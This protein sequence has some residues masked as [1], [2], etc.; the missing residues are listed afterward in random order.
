MR[1]EIEMMLSTAGCRWLTGL[2]P[3]SGS[4]RPRWL[5]LEASGSV[6]G[7][8]PDKSSPSFQDNQSRMQALVD[9]LKSKVERVVEGGGPKA[10]ERH[11]ARGK[12]VAR[13]R[14][15]GLLDPGK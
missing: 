2:R 7:S 14:I 15:N 13:E 8:E 3:L 9:E 5:S 12:L 11:T 6:V 10:I 1:I 4:A